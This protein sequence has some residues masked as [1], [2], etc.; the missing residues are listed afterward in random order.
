MFRRG[1]FRFAGKSINALMS[2]MELAAIDLIA[3]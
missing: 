3:V 1:L 2:T